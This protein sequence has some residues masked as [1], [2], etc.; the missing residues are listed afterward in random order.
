MNKQLSRVEIDKC[1]VDLEAMLTGKSAPAA[2]VRSD[3]PAPFAK[4]GEGRDR[5][6]ARRARIAEKSFWLES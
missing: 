6:K 2:R 4:R 3:D 1:L 5:R